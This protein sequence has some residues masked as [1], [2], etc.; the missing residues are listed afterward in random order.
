MSGGCYCKDGLVLDLNI[1]EC[2]K[3]EECGKQVD[4]KEIDKPGLR[5]LDYNNSA[6]L[7]YQLQLETSMW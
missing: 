6:E 1:N 4:Y 7:D 5:K 3:E 2:V